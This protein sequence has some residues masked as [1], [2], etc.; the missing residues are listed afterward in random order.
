MQFPYNSSGKYSKQ[1]F[2]RWGNN[3]K[4]RFLGVRFLIGGKTHYG[5]IRLS[6]TTQAK[7]AMTVEITAYAYET[8]ANK[9]TT[10][11]ATSGAASVAEVQPQMPKPAGLGM[12]ALGAEGLPLWRRDEILSSN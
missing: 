12:L 9:V 5:W 6:V 1:M 4:D 7:G 3:Q 11:G 10:A 2:G 8:I